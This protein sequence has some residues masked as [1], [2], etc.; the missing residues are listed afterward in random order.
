V[1]R[2]PLDLLGD[3]HCEVGQAVQVVAGA[4]QRIDHP[5]RVAVAG[6]A[7]FLAQKGVIGVV[8][9]NFPYNFCFAGL[10]DFADVVVAGLT[11]Y[12][13]GVHVLHLAAHDVPRNVGGSD[14]NIEY[15]MHDV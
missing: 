8:A 12:R 10:V 15:R 14:G 6:L 3:G 1:F 11:F 2:A 13:N 9:L 4:V 5:D 7:P